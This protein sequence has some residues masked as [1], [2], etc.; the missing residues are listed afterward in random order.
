[1]IDLA[2]ETVV[3]LTEAVNHLP[4]RRGGKKPH[5]STLYRWSKSGLE[6]IRVGGTLCTSIQALQRFCERM[7]ARDQAVR[8]APD[9]G[10]VPARRSPEEAARRL[11]EIGLK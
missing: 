4:R 7:T 11:D 8:P 10:I 1:M 6:T 9:D 3:S 2:N 5:P